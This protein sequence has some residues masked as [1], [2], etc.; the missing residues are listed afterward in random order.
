MTNAGKEKSGRIGE[1][2]I[3]YFNKCGYGYGKVG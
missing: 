1:G 2:D 3:G